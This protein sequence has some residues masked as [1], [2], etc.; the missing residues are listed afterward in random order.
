MKKYTIYLKKGLDY[1]VIT[2]FDNAPDT[3]IQAALKK[4]EG[5]SCIGWEH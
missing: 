4:N 1:L 3:A 2:I 5:Y